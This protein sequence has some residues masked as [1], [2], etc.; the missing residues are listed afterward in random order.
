VLPIPLLVSLQINIRRKS[1]LIAV[2]LLGLFTTVCS[3]MRMVQI[4]TIAK[5]GNSTM[6]V[7]WGTIEMNVGVS[8][9]L[10]PSPT[11]SNQHSTTQQKL[12][13]T[14]SRSLASPRSLPSS[15]TSAKRQSRSRRDRTSLER[16]RDTDANTS[17]TSSQKEIL[18]LES[19]LGDQNDGKSGKSAK[20]GITATVT[21]DI[22]VE[23][24]EGGKFRREE[25]WGERSAV[26]P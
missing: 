20:G 4:I 26:S 3:I 21:V 6:L 16:W 1:A 15:P 19:T 25:R 5:T 22:K 24:A 8:F 18:G 7:L 11:F 12:T 2:F 10:R 23:D 14:R 13:T 17:D 9:F